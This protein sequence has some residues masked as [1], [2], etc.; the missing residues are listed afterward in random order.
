MR[1]L[2]LTLWIPLAMLA[3]AGS[4]GAQEYPHGEMAADCED[5]HTDEAWTPV[6]E[7]IVFK[8]ADA[9]FPLAGSHK[10]VKCKSC[11]TTL[12][13]PKVATACA[14]CHRDVH[15]G[16]FGYKCESCHVAKS[17]DNRRQMWDLHSA[18]L[19]PLTGAHAT[20]DCQACHQENAPFQYALAPID[21]FSCHEAD[22]VGTTD[23]DHQ[24]AGFPTD[25]EICHST[26]SWDA[27]G[28]PDHD[29][30]FF[31]INSGRHAGEWSSCSD[32][33]VVPGNFQ[34]FECINCHEHSQSEMDDKHQDEP[35]YVY[36]STACYDCHPTG[37]E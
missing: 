7:P 16:E 32:C 17:W 20:L 14:D 13:F 34:I 15:R 35:G 21:C 25:C 2:T 29:A 33:H 4:V 8:H 23:P 28:F 12:E 37:R 31:P 3:I 18:T 27:L 10:K 24:A 22:Y 30:Q 36:E 5:C 26:R 11:H 6:R 9:G 1:T 19:L